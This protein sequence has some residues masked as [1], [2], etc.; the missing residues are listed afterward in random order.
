MHFLHHAKYIQLLQLVISRRGHPCRAG[1]NKNKTWR[2][3]GHVK[4]YDLFQHV[5]KQPGSL[6]GS[7]GQ[8]YCKKS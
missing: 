2:A 1:C 7:R 5:N 8:K 6:A 3:A 4:I